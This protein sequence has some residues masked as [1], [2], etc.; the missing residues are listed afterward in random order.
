MVTVIPASKLS[1]IELK[2]DST[3]QSF[4]T[5]PNMTKLGTLKAAQQGPYTISGFR[6]DS[7]DGAIALIKLQ[8]N[9]EGAHI[10][11][12]IFKTSDTRH[13]VIFG[14]NVHNDFPALRFSLNQLNHKLLPALKIAYDKRQA[15]AFAESGS[16]QLAEQLASKTR[17]GFSMPA[18]QIATSADTKLM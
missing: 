8:R 17:I 13:G 2:A 1:R 15:I 12:T 3:E 4:N 5:L 6:S 9:S 11:T 16:C 10:L 18:S 14:R 7:C